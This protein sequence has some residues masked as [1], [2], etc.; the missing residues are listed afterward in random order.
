M[1]LR[2]QPFMSNP[3]SWKSWEGG[4]VG[5][6]F[7]L[8][9]WLGGSD[10]SAVFLTDR[11]GHSDQKAAIKLIAEIP[12]ESE[13]QRARWR[14]AAQLSH[15]NLIRIDEIG[16]CQMNGKSLLYVVMEYA[17]ED[18]S[19]ILPQRALAAGEVIEMLPPLLDSLSY[20]HSKGLV[21]TRIKPS[22][23][24]AV[25][26]L[27]KLSTDQATSPV[28]SAGEGTRRDVYD[29]PETA[30]GIVSPAGD[31]WSV[32]AMLVEALTQ[33]PPFDPETPPRDRGVPASVPEPFRGIARECL[34]DDPK[35]RCS[36]ADIKARMQPAARSVPD[37]TPLGAAAKPRRNAQSIWR[38][39]IPIAI[40]LIFGL[41]VRAL[42]KAFSGKPSTSGQYKLVAPPS[43]SEPTA[44]TPAT[45]SSKPS[46]T[47]RSAAPA[48]PVRQPAATPK[49][50]AALQG[51]VLLRVVPDVPRS[52]KNTIT[53]T[54]KVDARVQVDATGKVT[55]VRLT[56]P[57]PSKYF[58]GLAE[59]AAEKWQ[60]SPLDMD[61]KAKESTWLL[62]FRFKRTSTQ[63]DAAR[64]NR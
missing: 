31:M 55:G 26:D 36:I 14:A 59:K 4:V 42:Y 2:G 20:L 35:R 28:E 52:A 22:N 56:T 46:A 58:A 23:V 5:G 57:G 49:K 30:A 48:A 45:P 41:G 61:G 21:H 17:E 15:P 6:K 33:K 40:L 1:L 39:L 43:T 9:Q 37:Q 8:R 24:L 27:L 3:E 51:E 50:A 7:P 44:A 10:H 62:M 53:G 18:L 54:I 32:G 38:L 11:H 47:G 64:V 19:Q 29:A 63:V 25:G 34:H 13:R 12:A 16:R 60:F